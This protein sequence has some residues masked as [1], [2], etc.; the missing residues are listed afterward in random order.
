MIAAYFWA[1]NDGMRDRVVESI[2]KH[3]F[4]TSAKRS[5]LLSLI[6]EWLGLF[7][8]FQQ[9]DLCSVQV[10]APSRSHILYQLSDAWGDVRRLARRFFRC[11]MTQVPS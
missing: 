2:S 10:D 1:S 6:A 11:C 4:L 7:A 8:P 9:V 3:A 5:S